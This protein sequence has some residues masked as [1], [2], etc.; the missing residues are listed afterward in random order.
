M[1]ALG[2]R[3]L[4]AS[5]NLFRKGTHI[6]QSKQ[7]VCFVSAPKGAKTKQKKT[8]FSSNQICNTTRE[9]R[10]VILQF[11]QSLHDKGNAECKSF[12]RNTTRETRSVFFQIVTRQGKR[13]V[14]F[15]RYTTRET[16]SAI[17]YLPK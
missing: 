15:F 10:S 4:T 8:V 2:G 9:T 14:S 6:G 12:F 17:L 13:G 7:E 5:L 11:F 3:A 1:G 16:R